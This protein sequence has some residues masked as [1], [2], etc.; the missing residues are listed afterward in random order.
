MQAGIIYKQ[1]FNKASNKCCSNCL[2]GNT[3]I[4]AEVLATTNKI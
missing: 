1:I 4:I 3:H 2:G